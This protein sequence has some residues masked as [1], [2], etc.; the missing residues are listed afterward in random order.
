MY[1]QINKGV[2]SLKQATVLSY[3]HLIDNLQQDGSKQI[4]HTDSYWRHSTLSTVFCLCK[5]DFGVKYYRKNNLNYLVNV[6]LKNNEISTDHSGT[7]YCGLMLE[8]Q[9]SI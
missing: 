5:D 3:Q 4:P 2:Y 1:I 7:N 8:C 9:H 6:L